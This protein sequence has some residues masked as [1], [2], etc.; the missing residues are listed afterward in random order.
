MSQPGVRS[1]APISLF[2]L[3]GI[4]L[5]VVTLAVGGA[6][7]FY[8]GVLKNQ[9]TESEATLN[10]AKE[11]FDPELIN[12]IVRLDTRIET[13]K[14]LLAGHTSV[15]P[16]FDYISTITLQ[17]VRFRNFSF[18]YLAPDKIIVTMQ[19]QGQSYASVALQ[20]DLLDEQKYLRETS[21]GDM[22][23]EPTGLVSFSVSTVIDPVLLSYD[24]SINPMTSTSS[25]LTI[26][27]TP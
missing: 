3:I 20:S 13:A 8:Q 27:Q 18:A 25:P 9:I 14:T 21:V 5:F 7:F 23:L 19:G 10:Q 12:E 24:Q 22:S 26:P 11:A 2:S 17:T 4:V 6:A 16:L 1:S 15:T